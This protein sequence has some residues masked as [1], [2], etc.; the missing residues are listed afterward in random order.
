MRLARAFGLLLLLASLC[1][2]QEI[3]RPTVNA[4]AT[5]PAESA[6]FGTKQTSS[7][8]A[9]SHDAAGL[10][11][12]STQTVSALKGTLRYKARMFTT[13][14]TSGNT[15]SALTLSVNS[16]F[17]IDVP[18]NGVADVLYSTNG[19][20]TWTSLQSDTAWS[21]QTNTVSLSASQ[22]LSMLRV[23]VCATAEA[24]PDVGVTAQLTAWDVWTSGTVSGGG[25]G[26]TG[27]G[28]GVK[29]RPPVI[30]S[31]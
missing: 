21:Q 30:V 13:W 14:A 29:R 27:S 31:K 25:G 11:T 26:G 20:G 24:E 15:Y 16:A 23:L 2:A 17:S 7:A 4:D 18:G 3:L 28:S 9:N 5:K 8:M 22:D 10:A 6:C 1:G 12:S 19:G